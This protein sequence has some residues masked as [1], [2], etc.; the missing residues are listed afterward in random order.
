MA[1]HQNITKIMSDI[2]REQEHLEGDNSARLMIQGNH[3][4][5]HK[6]RVHM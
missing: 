4:I 1:T 6:I 2:A 3:D 5:E